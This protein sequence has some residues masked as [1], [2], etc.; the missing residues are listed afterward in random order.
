MLPEMPD[1]PVF[2]PLIDIRPRD[3]LETARPGRYG[4]WRV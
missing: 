3:G 4:R 1:W 2:A